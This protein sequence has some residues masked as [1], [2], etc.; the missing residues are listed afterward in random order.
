MVRR[1]RT[2]PSNIARSARHL[3]PRYSYS[4][5]L[6]RAGSP[7]LLTFGSLCLASLTFQGI[8][9]VC[10]AHRTAAAPAQP[11]AL[12]SIAAHPI[13]I[14]TSLPTP[15]PARP[16]VSPAPTPSLFTHSAV[17]SPTLQPAATATATTPTPNPTPPPLP[18]AGP[19]QPEQFRVVLKLPA[20]NSS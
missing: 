1:T 5:F 19:R 8:M 12:P 4:A 3:Y 13:L 10:P 9:S 16:P 2:L 11:A 7:G 18:T 15:P 17:P 6:T 20:K 14:S